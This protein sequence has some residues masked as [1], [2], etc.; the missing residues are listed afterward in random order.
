MME[1]YRI[2][3]A[4]GIRFDFDDPVRHVSEFAATI[5]NASPS[6]RLDHLA[7]RRSEIDVINGQVVDLSRELGLVAP[8]TRACARSCASGN[9]VSPDCRGRQM[10]PDALRL[11]PATAARPL[12]PWSW[13]PGRGV[14]EGLGDI[15][16]P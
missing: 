4:K 1:A 14:L 11:K 13:W 3:V 6:M 8:T 7:G 16:V 12:Q 9:L 10:G 5:P 2:G 15:G